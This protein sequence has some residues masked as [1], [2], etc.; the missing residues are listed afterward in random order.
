MV[1]LPVKALVAG[2]NKPWRSAFIEAL[3]DEGCDLHTATSGFEALELLRK[4]PYSVVIIDDSLSDVGAL[5]LCL[6]LRDLVNEMPVVMVAGED[7]A[8]Y[9]PF[10]RRVGLF[11][12]GR[13]TTV[14][15]NVGHAVERARRKAYAL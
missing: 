4:E 8:K 5:E 2:E 1:A 14:L 6:N 12:V 15:R 9:V 11:F 7:L 10:W 13:R 3:Y